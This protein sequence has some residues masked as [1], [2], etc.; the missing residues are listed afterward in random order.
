MVDPKP[1]SQH[2]AEARAKYGAAATSK[3]GIIMPSAS[4]PSDVAARFKKEAPQDPL[5][6][7]IDIISRPLYGVTETLQ[8]GMEEG[9]KQWDAQQAGKEYDF[10]GGVG[11]QLAAPFRGVFSTAQGDKP[12]TSDL[13]EQTADTYGPMLDKNYQDVQDNVNPVAKGIGGF[14]GD[15]ALDPLT[16]IPGA[17]VA[18]IGRSAAKA[19][20]A[21]AKAVGAGAAVAAAARGV[22]KVSSKLGK[23]AKAAEETEATKSLLSPTEE[24]EI[25]TILSSVQAGKKVTKKQ[26]DQLT[27]IA[28]NVGQKIA[29]DWRAKKNIVGELQKLIATTP[30]EAKALKASKAVPEARPVNVKAGTVDD[31]RGQYLNSVEQGAPEIMITLPKGQT[32]SLSEVMASPKTARNA[33][34][35]ED[36]FA[37]YQKL[38]DALGGRVD[39]GLRLVDTEGMTASQLIF[40]KRVVDPEYPVAQFNGKT[41]SATEATEKLSDKTLP[42]IDRRN[43]LD[44]T[45]AVME[46][47]IRESSGRL[48]AAA[49]RKPSNDF[50]T[51]RFRTYLQSADAKKTRN[52]LGP[53][54][55]DMLGRMTSSSKFETTVGRLLE[56]MNNERSLDNIV[57]NDELNKFEQALMDLIGIDVAETNALRRQ[58]FSAVDSDFSAGLAEAQA[59]GKAAEYVIRASGGTD[60]EVEELVPFLEKFIKQTFDP[61]RDAFSDKK[62]TASRSATGVART[63][64]IQGAGLGKREREFNG[65]DAWTLQRQ[66]TKKI[67]DVADNKLKLSGAERAEYVKKATMRQM[68]YAEAVLDKLG[69][70][71][72]LGVGKTKV[73]LSFSQVVSILNDMDPDLVNKVFFNGGTRVVTTNALE[74]IAAVTR[75][76]IFRPIYVKDKN[77]KAIQQMERDLD[78]KVVKDEAGYSVP[79]Y[80]EVDVNPENLAELL[81]RP[82]KNEKDEFVFN[83]FTEV[84]Q[85][86][87]RGKQGKTDPYRLTEDFVTTLFAA[88]PAFKQRNLANIAIYKQR[89]NPEAVDLTNAQLKAIRQAVNTPGYTR[90]AL[91]TIAEMSKQI[92]L[93]GAESGVLDLSKIAAKLMTLQQLPVGVMEATKN[94]SKAIRVGETALKTDG[95]KGSD[96][97]AEMMQ[98]ENAAFADEA[99]KISDDV[100]A[101]DQNDVGA[102]IEDVE[103]SKAHGAVMTGFAKL[104]DPFMRRFSRNYQMEHISDTIHSHGNLIREFRG[105]FTDVLNDLVRKHFGKAKNINATKISEVFSEI[106]KGIP[107]SPEN[108]V[109]REDLDKIM[110]Q[111]FDIDGKGWANDF[112]FIGGISPQS[113]VEY[114]K[115]VDINKALSG[116]SIDEVFD[117]NK[118]ITEAKTEGISPWEMASRQW[119]T[120]NVA[121]P[122][123]FLGRWHGALLNA[124]VDGAL[125]HDA[126]RIFRKMGATASQKTLGYVKLSTKSGSL[127]AFVPT[128]VYVRE[129]LA[130]EFERMAEFIKEA[131]TPGGKFGNWLNNY[132]LPFQDT[133]K[134]TITLPRLGH[135]IR[136]MV[137]DLSLT[138]MAEGTRYSRRAMKDSIRMLK[139]RGQYT[140]LD[141]N[142]ALEAQGLTDLP[143]GGD[144]ISKGKY[145]DLSIE[146]LYAVAQKKGLLPTF[147][148]GEDLAAETGSGLRNF[149]SKASLRGGRFEKKLGGFS[150]GRDHLARMHHFLQYVYK[151]QKDGGYK[152]LDD[153]MDQ[154]SRQVKKYHPDAA[155]LTPFEAKYMRNVI[156]FY[157][158]MRGAIPAIVVSA[159]MKPG[160]AMVFPKASYNLAISMGV[161]PNSLSDPFPQDQ[162][163]PSFL[164]EQATGPVAKIDGKYYSVAPGIANIDVVNQFGTDPIRGLLGMISPLL[165]VPFEIASGSK[166]QTGTRIKD[167]SDY[168]DSNIP[169]VNYVSNITGTSVTGSVASLLSGQGVDQQADVK[170]GNKD[171][172]DQMLS[173]VNWMTGA[174][175]QNVSKPNYINLGE[176]EQRN[177]EGD[178]RNAF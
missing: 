94:T 32:V 127:N 167:V 3:K 151:G 158:W 15:V 8:T 139:F 132:F 141:L 112:G 54:L 78:G 116:S 130:N 118:I 176:I 113:M 59:A 172:T 76:K 99:S 48:P 40:Y 85:Y 120:L 30:A 140:G 162:L 174:G 155:M 80:E 77:G 110:A 23:G 135:H 89:F 70:P 164:T 138:Y 33:K 29:K 36:R 126:I 18:T 81:Q 131:R 144:I 7:A 4:A 35:L 173:F 72:W 20:G 137:G 145:G 24:A 34:I 12:M 166:L 64:D 1:F 146:F 136:N 161:D 171:A 119:R 14:V 87:K 115:S 107:S 134:Y 153:L 28:P 57:K 10:W 149:L 19:L 46:D 43:I 133:W 52:V 168:L 175:V 157:S 88:E 160:R 83:A 74:A 44:S 67:A 163:F 177:R 31:F 13:I 95:I 16:W 121:D 38:Y 27:K 122:I 102:R 66:L 73:Q 105:E 90:E 82:V 154:A 84:G 17:A 91:Y 170:A 39:A 124:K 2:L 147:R 169:G 123:D 142:K 55:T 114:L 108:A 96:E 5:S 86:A 62:Y 165:R 143:K 71:L 93:T 111:L 156:P 22:E 9:K 178:N 42:A 58:A 60:A 6:W 47:V 117:M 79:A 128:N 101:Y 92:D 50:F 148:V 41:L 56:L 104:M 65:F 53:E 69:I 150:E 97:A 106:Q 21:G 152:N 129:D 63:S 159:M 103:A 49:M 26:L 125:A 45:K 11:N 109:L 51:K 100:H 37:K 75:G 68:A 61:K 25:Q 98:R